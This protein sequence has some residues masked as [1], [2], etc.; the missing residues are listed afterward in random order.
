MINE[1]C[2]MTNKGCHITNEGCHM[3]NE[4]CHM[5]NGGCH[6]T[7]EGRYMTPELT[8]P[9]AP[10]YGGHQRTVCGLYALEDPLLQLE[11]LAARYPLFKLIKVPILGRHH[12]ICHVIYHVRERYNHTVRRSA[13]DG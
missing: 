2:H 5:T 1:G 4:G 10:A 13:G 6:M 3:T 12:V 9:K 8:S 11:H 7:N